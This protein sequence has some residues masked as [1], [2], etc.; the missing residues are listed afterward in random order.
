MKVVFTGK[1]PASTDLYSPGVIAG[2]TLYL[3]GQIPVIP[4]TGELCSGGFAEQAEQV[5]KNISA[6]LSSAGTDFSRVV[7]TTCFLRDASDFAEFNRIYA[8][9]FTGGPSGIKPARSCVAVSALPKG[10]LVEVEVIAA[11]EDE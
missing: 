6:L 7:K 1:A 8:R 2:K 9:Y 10:V 5:M 3:S 4:A 11:L